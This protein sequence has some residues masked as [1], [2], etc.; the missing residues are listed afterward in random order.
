MELTR[1]GETILDDGGAFADSRPATNKKR[2]LNYGHWLNYIRLRWPDL[3]PAKPASRICPETLA[4]WIEILEQTVASYTR[5]MRASDLMIIARAVDPAADW[6]FLRRAVRALAGRAEPTANKEPRIQSSVRLLELGLG[7]MQEAKGKCATRPARA[8]VLYRDGLIIA[9]LALRPLR[10]RNLTALELGRTLQGG[11][12]GWRITIP[13]SETK[14]YRGFDVEW[15][16]NLGD[17]LETY[18]SRYRP[19]LLRDARSQALWVGGSGSSLAAHT[20][21]QAIV[22]RTRAVLGIS[23]N[24]HL[25][26]D[27]AASTLAVEDPVHV[28]AAATI[29]GHASSRTTHK[30]YIQANTLSASRRHFAV[31]TARRRTEKPITRITRAM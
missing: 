18:L 19:S 25:F 6:T 1:F 13:A 2:L 23:I 17:A 5:L 16:S 20:I 7:L 28:G 21:G 8:A 30:H 31:I 3:L 29:L 26:R 11:P 27:C 14:T 12:G 15:P 10:L 22:G 4:G 24:P 9:L